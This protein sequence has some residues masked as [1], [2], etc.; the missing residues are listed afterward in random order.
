[1][2]YILAVS[3]VTTVA[4]QGRG[5]AARCH[6]WKNSIVA[7]L[8]HGLEGELSGKLAGLYTQKEIDEAAKD[9]KVKLATSEVGLQLVSVEPRELVQWQADTDGVVR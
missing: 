1:M 6:V 4:L 7:A 5:G 8:C 3:F 2:L 9:T